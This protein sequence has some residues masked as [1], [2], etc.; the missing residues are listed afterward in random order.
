MLAIASVLWDSARTTPTRCADA[1]KGVH[2]D[3]GALPG[4]VTEGRP[5]AQEYGLEVGIRQLALGLLGHDLAGRL[6]SDRGNR[7]VL[8][9]GRC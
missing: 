5:V 6:V 9:A 8:A 7:R 2:H 3:L 1:V 4:R